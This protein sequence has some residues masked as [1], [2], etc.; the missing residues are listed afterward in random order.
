MRI[1]HFF[2]L[3]CVASVAA[4]AHFS[5]I[6][7]L[8]GGDAAEM[9][10]GEAP[11]TYDTVNP[12]IAKSGKLYIRDAEGQVTPLTFSQ[13][14]HRFV[15]P[16]PGQGPRVV[17]GQANLGANHRGNLAIPHILMYYPKTVIGSPFGERS[18]VGGEQAVELVTLGEPGAVKL[19]ALWRGAPLANVEITVIAPG[20]K[21]AKMTTGADGVVGPFAAPG[22]YG[23]WARHWEDKEGEYE[24]TAY[25]QVRH[26]AMLVFDAPPAPVKAAPLPEPTSSFGAV[27]DNGWLYVYGGHIAR[28]HSYSTESVSGRFSRRRLDSAE[29][30]S[31]P[32]GP[33]LQGTNLAA[34]GGRICR[35]GGMAPRNAPGA[36]SDIHSIAGNACYEPDQRAWREIPA[37]P[38]PRSS[39]DVAVIGDRLIVT[40]GW[41]LRGSEPTDWAKSTLWLD[42]KNPAAGWREAAA[43]PFERRALVTAVSGGRMYVIGGIQPSGQVSTGVDIYDPAQDQWSKGPALPGPAMNGFAPA[44]AVKDGRLYVSVG[45]GSLLR[46]DEAGARWVEA[47]LGAP[48]L[49]HRMV[50]DGRGLLVLGGAIKGKNLDLAESIPLP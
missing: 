43:Q 44:A 22:R 5:W 24:G 13:D 9:I 29:W 36:K 21:P 37:L 1:F 4:H 42:L 47:G 26:Y 14:G 10:I 35:I 40:G 11:G 38:A 3:A 2:I 12:A 39:H 31:L 49:A 25:K 32:A 28:T 30:E 8:P 34:H 45:D 23:A 19:K 17:Y 15:M 6:L 46:L 33:A 20:A 41:N 7:P 48:R 27:T 16:L 50:P 18:V